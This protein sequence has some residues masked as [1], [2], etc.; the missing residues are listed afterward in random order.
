MRLED[1]MKMPGAQSAALGEFGQRQLLATQLDPAAGIGDDGCI[2]LFRRRAIVQ[3]MSVLRLST[4]V[5]T[6]SRR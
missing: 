3:L 5:A 6:R 2:F 4:T 1:A